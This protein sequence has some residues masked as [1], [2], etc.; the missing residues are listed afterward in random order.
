MTKLPNPNSAAAFESF[1]KKYPLD[2][3]EDFNEGKFID[4]VRNPF[5]FLT[6]SGLEQLNETGHKFFDRYNKYGHHFPDQ[7]EWRWEAPEDFLSVWDVQVFSTNYLR[8]VM[9]VQSFLD[10]MLGT[11][12][13][14]P[15]QEKPLDPSVTQEVNVPN[16]AW[17]GPDDSEP[18][19]QVHVRDVK[20]D[21]LNAFDR[22]PDLISDL[23]GEVMQHERFFKRDSNAAPLAARLANIL[24][25]LVRPKRKDFSRRSPSG[26][27][28]VEAADHFVCRGAH[29]VPLSRFTDCSHDERVEQTL[30][31]MSHQTTTHLAWRFRQWYQ[32]ERLLAVIAAPPL[33]EVA[34][35]LATTPKL[36]IRDRHP[37][38]VYS[39]HDI[40]LLGLLYGIGA[41]FL[42][43]DD[44]G[45]WR[46][47]PKYG[48]HLTFE[49][50]RV[51]DDDSGNSHV[52]RV[53]LNGEPVL[54]A[55]KEASSS[56]HERMVQTGNGPQ[57]MLLVEDFLEIVGKLED[58]GGFD[59]DQ[60]LGKA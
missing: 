30:A 27:N 13:L 7:Q 56:G 4:V 34:D 45:D 21:P 31:A 18:L 26:I 58:A 5:G 47:W 46:Y 38:V 49:L 42:A 2:I 28:W 6:Q 8:T 32:N 15:T 29:N 41:D 20:H 40:T 37:F 33:R 53:L 9:S 54:T 39:C 57:H 12:L 25:G 24:P 16:H 10:G 1:S 11:G 50:V 52:V 44:T 51:N 48:S 60:L 55:K 23:V 35:Q 17:K 22:N 19:I 59:F 14:L 43:D 36:G 3:N